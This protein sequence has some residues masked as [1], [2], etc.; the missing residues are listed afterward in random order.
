MFDQAQELLDHY[1]QS[2]PP[3]MIM[4]STYSSF[5]SFAGPVRTTETV[6]A[7]AMLS[8]ARNQRDSELSQRLYDRMTSL[9]PGQKPAL[10]SASILLSNTYLSTGEHERAQEI[11][12]KRIKQFG[13]KVKPG[14]SLTD[15]NG[16]LVVISHE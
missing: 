6:L 3:S 5:P 2:H 11:R 1:E 14:L 9:F 4:Y 10:I 15:V 13:R 12:L 8:G 7:V 16:E